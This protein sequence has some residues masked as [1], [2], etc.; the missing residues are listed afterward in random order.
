MNPAVPTVTAL[1]ERFPALAGLSPGGRTPRSIPFVQQTAGSDCG[2]ACLAMVL[3]FHG[4][5]VPLDEVR[6]M[7]GV[8]LDGTDALSLVETARR[9]GL[10][11]RGVKIDDIQH[12]Q[13]LTRGSVLHWRFDHWVVLDSLETDGAWIVDPLH[14]RRRVG[15]RE[16]RQA[17]TG[18]ALVFQPA[19]DF[20]PGGQKPSGIRRYLQ[21]ILSQS[22]LIWRILTISVLIQALGL[23]IPWVTGLLVDRVVPRH[24]VRLLTVLSLGLAAIVLFDLISSVIRAHLVLHLRTHLDAEMTLGFLSH[25]IDLPYAFF[26]RR[27]AGDLMMRLNSNSTIRE[28][29]TSS[30]MSGILDGVLVGLYFLVLFSVHTGLTLLVVGLGAV[31]IALFLAT[32]RRYRD[33]MSEMLQAQATSRNYQVQMLTGIETLKAMGAEQKAVEHWTHLFVDEL[34]VSLAQ[35][36]L[37]A[38]FDSLLSA[39]GKASPFVILIFGAS[40]VL[41]GEL[42]LGTML[43][44]NALAAGVLGPLSALVATALQLQLLGSYLERINDVLDTAKEQ[45]SSQVS[46]AGELKGLVTL[47]RVSFQYGPSAPLVVREV[48]TEIQPGSFVAIVGTSGAG[49]STLAHLLLGLYRPTS[50]RILFDGND[51]ASLDLGSLRRQLGIVPQQPYLFGTSIRH[52]IALAD[53]S[54]PLH[55]VI[56][57]AQIAQ[58]HADITAMPMGYDTML[59]DGGVSLSGGQRQR[60]ALARALVRRPAILL[61][62]EAT[63]ALDALTE[64]RI[65]QQLE[66]LDCTRVVIAHRL[67]TIAAADVILVMDGGRVVEAGD[68]ETLMARSGA[69]VELVEAQLQRQQV[70]SLTLLRQ[71]RVSGDLWTA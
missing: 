4:K 62:D 55:Q 44:L 15:S 23:A 61:L 25:L 10:R 38:I 24:D 35:G 26:Q 51:L 54:L 3:A 39:L 36:R 50:G 11:G 37:S 46:P 59:A 14:G 53:P 33:L 63:S 57:A 8:S 31:R 1:L 2:V 42:S 58:I 49:K 56:E 9:L 68:H 32:K 6:A 13:Y 47:D 17:F 28:I 34:N 64:R 43:A 30:A 40:K 29:L 22:G 71:R 7:T 66:T 52:N 19:D 5:Y 69:Y 45:D 21:Q 70:E 27:S 60:I 20:E 18:V 41:A 65:Q 67:S 48:S 16:L 12:L